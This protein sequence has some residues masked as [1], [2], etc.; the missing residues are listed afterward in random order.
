M[1]SVVEQ[2]AEDSLAGIAVTN[3]YYD[4]NHFIKAYKGYT[5]ALP[6]SVK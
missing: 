2:Q 4:Q 1:A 3:G 6:S 5:G